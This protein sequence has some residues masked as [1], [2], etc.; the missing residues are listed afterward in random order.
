MIN[1]MQTFF[2]GMLRTWSIPIV[3]MLS[4]ASGFTTYYGM[5][6][7]IIPWIALVI[8]VAIQSIVVICTLELAGI[9][10]RANRMRYFSVLVSLV[11]ALVASVSF[12]YF[13]FYEVSEKD[14][15]HIQRLNDIRTDIKSYLNEVLPFKS[16]VLAQ[17]RA[18]LE[19]ASKE[20]SL[21]YFGTHPEIVPGFRNQVGK[22]PFWERYNEIY[23]AKKQAFS[24][25]QTEFS[26]LDKSVQELQSSLTNLDIAIDVETAYYDVIS[27]F[28]NVQFKVNQ[29]AS[30]FG[31]SLPEPPMLLTYKQFIEEVKPSMAM[32][33]GFSLFAFGC[34]AMVDFFTVLLSYRLEFT[35]PGPLT[36]DEEELVF[37][38]LRQFTQFRINKNDELEMIIE[39]SNIEKARRYSDWSRMFAVG[40]LLSRGFLRKIDNRTVEFAPNLYPLIAA[41]M[42]DKLTKLRAEAQLARKVGEHE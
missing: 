36:A 41:K 29:L 13:K 7:F 16:K 19:Q 2:V 10:W 14:S 1:R 17:K 6:H 23:Q 3:L 9:H 28:Q 40:L 15:I 25:L 39:K 21:A 37:E 27:N 18:D 26:A 8:T 35:A 33:N 11:I 5:S 30:E 32:W 20:V 38:C 31:Q 12:S 22:G 34:A 24:E 42:G 4:V